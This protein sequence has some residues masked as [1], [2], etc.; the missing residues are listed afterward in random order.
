MMKKEIIVAKDDKHLQ[1]I[2]KVEIGKYGN[3]CDLNH[4]DV[5][6]I[7]DMSFMFYHS[8][9][10]GDI[11]KWNIINVTKMMNMFANSQ[12]NG[13]ISR[14][15]LNN[16][17]SM[18]GMFAYSQF[19]GDINNWNVQNVIK[20][21][22]IFHESKFTG[23]L[24]AWTPYSLKDSLCLSNNPSFNIPYWGN[25]KTNT[26]IREA[27]ALK[28]KAELDQELSIMTNSTPKNKVKL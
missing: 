24:N 1:Q 10:N 20:M 6:Q 5:S 19:N 17:T 9:F 8:K 25:L 28:Q 11:S 21:D 15:N 22:N 2:I 12:F 7:T 27:I 18:F 13:D 4:I 14:W 23:N 16:I 26:E 3:N